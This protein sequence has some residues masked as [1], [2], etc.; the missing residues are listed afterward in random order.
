MCGRYFLDGD[1]LAT[2]LLD[3]YAA[4]PGADGDFSR[5]AADSSRHRAVRMANALFMIL[6][7]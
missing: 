6:S 5:A 3:G 7:S 2:E 4:A 1:A